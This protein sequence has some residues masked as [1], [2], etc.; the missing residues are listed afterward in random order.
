M[1]K[2]RKIP[3]QPLIE[4][5]QDLYDSGADFIDLSGEQSDKG[6]APKDI[7]QITIKPEY[8]LHH[9]DEDDES[10]QEIEMDYSD[11]NDT[12]SGDRRSLSEDDINDLI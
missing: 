12:P 6:D 3:L 8:M 2:L 10:T 1:L 7:I 9:E 11:D 4:I 5:L